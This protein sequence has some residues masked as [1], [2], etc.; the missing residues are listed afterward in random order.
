MSKLNLGCGNSPKEG[1]KNIDISLT[2]KADEFYDISKGIKEKDNSCEEVHCGCILEQIDS[3]KDFIFVLNEIWRVLKSDGVLTGYV[4]ST[5]PGVLYLDPMDKR[6]F[7][8]ESFNYFD[9][10]KTAYINFGKN[11][12]F[13]PWTNIDV[14]LNEGAIILF[15]MT[16][17]K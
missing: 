10:D 15:S 2:A 13:K 8:L 3:N 16:P 5:A 1:F 17:K 4:P 12:G 7:Q 6:F 14:Q 9:Y 11:Y